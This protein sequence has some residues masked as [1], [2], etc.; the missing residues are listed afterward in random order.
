[1]VRSYVRLIN[2]PGNLGRINIPN[3]L[4]SRKSEGWKVDVGRAWRIRKYNN[5]VFR[6]AMRALN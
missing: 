1:M 2:V 6:L 3:R 4:F 5:A